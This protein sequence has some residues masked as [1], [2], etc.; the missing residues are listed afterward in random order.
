MMNTSGISKNHDKKIN[1]M[2]SVEFTSGTSGEKF[3]ILKSSQLRLKES[4]YLFKR[5]KE[6]NSNISLS[7]SFLFLHSNQEILNRI[8][9]WEFKPDDLEDITNIML[10]M[11]KFWIFATPLIYKKLS[12]YL[13]ESK[14]K[15]I[16]EQ[17]LFCEYTSQSFEENEKMELSKTYRTK[18]V[19]NYGTREFWNIAYECKEGKLHVNDEYL[20]VD[21]VDEN[22]KIIREKNKVGTIIVTHIENKEMCFLKYRLGDRGRFIDGE[23]K[24]GA[25]SKIIELCGDR[26]NELLINTQYSGKNVFRR[27]MRGIYFED[28]ISC[29]RDIKIIQDEQFHISVYIDKNGEKDVFIEERFRQ[30]VGRIVENIEKFSFDFYYFIPVELVAKF[31]FKEN[32]FL[33]TLS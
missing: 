23:C 29:I 9:L 26:A 20:R 3:P 19:N 32:I 1:N 22:G 16:Q 8:N 7:N 4:R 17:I 21:I 27:V 33:N 28:K 14:K 25:K 13:A 6:Y 30:R 31:T 15:F 2:W 24:C 10:D 12:L 11:E 5:R 18:F